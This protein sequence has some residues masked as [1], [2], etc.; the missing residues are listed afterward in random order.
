M[1]GTGGASF[2]EFSLVTFFFQEKESDKTCMETGLEMKYVSKGRQGI[3][4]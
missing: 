2:L 4:R 3:Q 1:K